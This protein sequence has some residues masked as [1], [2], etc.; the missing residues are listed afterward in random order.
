MVGRRLGSTEGNM[1][2][3]NSASV[4]K[5]ALLIDSNNVSATFMPLIMREAAKIGAVTIH[6]ISF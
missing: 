4:T 2:G 5:L 3:D 6:R 1:N